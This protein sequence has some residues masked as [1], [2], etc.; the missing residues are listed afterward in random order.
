MPDPTSDP[1]LAPVAVGTD[2]SPPAARAVAWAADDSARWGRPLHIVHVAERWVYDI[3][4][5]PPPGMRDS[6]SEEGMRI[7]AAARA[8][9]ER[10]HP[11]V[12]VTTELLQET[13]A[14]ALCERSKRSFEVVLG[15][16]GLGGFTSLLLGSTGLRV[17]GCAPGPVVVV[18]GEH[19]AE[20]G[21]VVVGVD[22][23]EVS[24]AALEYAFEAASVRSARLRVTHAW[25]LSATLA[26]AEFVVDLTEMEDDTRLSLTQALAPWRK[27]YPDVEVAEDVVRDHPVSALADASGRADLLVVGSHG[28]SGIGTLRLGSVGHGVIHHARSPVAVVRPRA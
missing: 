15:H 22:L 3:P 2:G 18:R 21:E 12:S 20:R 4:L 14:H 8:R 17:A 7:L 16:R 24:A 11:E 9:A 13:T 1:T 27:R 28:R 19:T 23:S 5:F 10:R 26:A 25:Q 6:I